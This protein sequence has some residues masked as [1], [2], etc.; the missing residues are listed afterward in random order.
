ML[1]QEVKQLLEKRLQDKGISQ[2]ELAKNLNVSGATL[3][4]ILNDKW[5][6]IKESMFLSIRN[7]LNPAEWQLIETRNYREIFEMCNHA[8]TQKMFIS[9]VGNEG[10]GKTESL[11]AYYRQN[12]N[13]YMITCD[14]GMNP[15][16]LFSQLAKEMGLPSQ[17]PV[18]ELKKQIINA[19]NQ[20]FSPLVIVDEISKVA[21]PNLTHFQDLWDG[22]KS[23][24]GLILSGAPH[25]FERFRQ[26]ANNRKIGM[27]ELYSRISYQYELK[28]PAK[29]EIEAICKAN[30]I[31]DRES[32]E[33]AKIASNFRLLSHYINNK[34]YGLI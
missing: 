4:N 29:T 24:G 14:K 1:H 21:L 15:K 6:N 13:T 5:E 34:K 20:Q 8:R 17:M 10:L 25:F 22:I 18:Y 32:I 27:P 28:Q 12:P 7:K 2:N 16:Q 26:S 11:Q 19:L 31:E 3:S 23:N 30:G 33:N 9:I